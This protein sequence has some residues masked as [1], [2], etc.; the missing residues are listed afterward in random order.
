MGAGTGLTI[1][2]AA[3]GSAKLAEKLLG[4][5]ADYLGQG[6]KHWTEKRVTNIQ[7][8]FRIAAN[9][10]G[11]DLDKE[12]AV[13]PRVLKGILDEGSFCDDPLTFQM[14]TLN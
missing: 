8:I 11:E 9:R 10:L 12:D 1:L 14:I 6:L 3:L 2:G 13:P 4:P 7:N 5:T